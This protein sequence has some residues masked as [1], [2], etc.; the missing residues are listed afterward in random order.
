MSYFIFL[1]LSR[2]CCEKHLTM[3]QNELWKKR[4]QSTQVLNV[5]RLFICLFVRCPLGVYF[6]LYQEPRKG[7]LK[8]S[9]QKTPLSDQFRTPC[10]SLSSFLGYMAAILLFP[11]HAY[12]SISSLYFPQA[13]PPQNTLTLSHLP[14]PTRFGKY[15]LYGGE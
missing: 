11:Y 3:Y 9:A 7:S 1:H 6:Y 8:K 13:S 4:E 14:S 15:I 10:H 5:K 2:E 12:F